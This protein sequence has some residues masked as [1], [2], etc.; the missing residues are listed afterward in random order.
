LPAV[1]EK[2]PTAAQRTRRGAA[3]GRTRGG[4]RAPVVASRDPHW[5]HWDHHRDHHWNHHRYRWYNNAWVLVDPGIYAYGY[6]PFG[7]DY[8]NYYYDNGYDYGPETV[9]VATVPDTDAL[10]DNVQQQLANA[11]YYN[12]PID[13]ILGSGTRAAIRQ[14]QADNGLAV[15][16]TITQSLLQSL[17]LA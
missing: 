17:G 1:A 11:G 4:A 7:Y 16:G 6:Y 9:S 5:H 8:G 14:Y 3:A 2:N 13:D 10:V 12:G 15:T